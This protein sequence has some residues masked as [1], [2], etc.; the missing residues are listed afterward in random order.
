MIPRPLLGPPHCAGELTVAMLNGAAERL[1][2][3]LAE[4]QRHFTAGGFLGSSSVE[5]LEPGHR[6]AVVGDQPGCLARPR[7]ALLVGPLVV[8]ACAVRRNASAQPP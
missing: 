8:T 7:T 5:P 4:I 2:G 1:L 3:A 6:P